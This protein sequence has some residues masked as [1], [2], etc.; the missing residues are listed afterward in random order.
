MTLVGWLGTFITLI[1]NVVIPL[2]VALAVL[3]FI[4]N[5]FRFFILQSGSEEGRQKAKRLMLYGLLA[6]VII[7]TIWGIV[8]IL[9]KTFGISG[10]LV[11]CPDYLNDQT[12]VLGGSVEDCYKPNSA[13]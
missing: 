12:P 8:N 11:P 5:V 1:N 13:I 4:W 3:F 10:P 2:I 9:I 7:L 6:L